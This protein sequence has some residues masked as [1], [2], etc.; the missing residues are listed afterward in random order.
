MTEQEMKDVADKVERIAM[1]RRKR[2]DRQEKLNALNGFIKSRK[3]ADHV[4]ITIK[5]RDEKGYNRTFE[6]IISGGILQ[7]ALINEIADCTRRIVAL[8]GTP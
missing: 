3:P 6:Y 5:G 2:E 8:G 7:Q 4:E 1:N